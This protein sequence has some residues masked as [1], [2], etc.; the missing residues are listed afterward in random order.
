MHSHSQQYSS[1]S[2]SS[3]SS[4]PS[5]SLHTQHALTLYRGCVDVGLW[6][7]LVIEHR[8]GGER[9][10]FSSRP[11]GAAANTVAAPGGQRKPRKHRDNRRRVERK[12]RWLE[13]KRASSVA[14]Q[15][16]AAAASVAAVCTQSAPVEGPAAAEI[17]TAAVGPTV[18]GSLTPSPVVERAAKKRK[19]G[20]PRDSAIIPQTDGGDRSLPLSPVTPPFSTPCVLLPVRLALTFLT[21]PP[22][23]PPVPNVSTIAPEAKIALPPASV[24]H[25]IISAPAPEQPPALDP[26]RPTVN[27]AAKERIQLPI[28]TICKIRKRMPTD[29]CC[30]W[31]FPPLAPLGPNI[32]GLDPSL[33][34]RFE[35]PPAPS[36]SIPAPV[37][38][39][40]PAAKER[41]R[42]PGCMLC[43][44]KPCFP[45]LTIEVRL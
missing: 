40:A 1:N 9:I 5:I 36:V 32:S 24:D 25:I 39:S 17:E 20:T 3:S 30:L 12:R 44:V 4:V 38:P 37:Q 35:P 31:C 34:A 43:K 16:K 15:S 14:A 8:Q 42:M 45:V 21:D 10:T 26:L 7:R 18:C 28:C 2:S 11:P 33:E 13:N 6:A 27:T 23:A 29:L 19:A 22:L 41:I